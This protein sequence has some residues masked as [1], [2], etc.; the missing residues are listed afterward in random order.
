MIFDEN[1]AK[2][3]PEPENHF[4]IKCIVPGPAQDSEYPSTEKLATGI[5]RQPVRGAPF[6][7]TP[8]RCIVLLLRR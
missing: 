6:H 5:V 8:T 3:P 1:S 2:K 4:P 7:L